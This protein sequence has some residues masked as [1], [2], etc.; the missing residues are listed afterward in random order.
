MFADK[1]I[2]LSLRSR[3]FP[4]SICVT[5]LMWDDL[6]LLAW[7]GEGGQDMS[8]KQDM[9]RGTGHVSK[10]DTRRDPPKKQGRGD[11]TRVL[12]PTPTSKGIP[13]EC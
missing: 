11:R 12:S 9:F 6:V 2:P 5:L 7:E 8:G 1:S 13:R 4:A 3:S 10:S